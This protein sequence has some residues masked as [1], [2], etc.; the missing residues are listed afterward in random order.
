MSLIC[1]NRILVWLV[2]YLSIPKSSV[3][4]PHYFH[5]LILVFLLFNPPEMQLGLCL[6][7]WVPKTWPAGHCFAQ[8]VDLGRAAEHREVGCTALFCGEWNQPPFLGLRRA[9][10]LFCLGINCEPSVV[11]ECG[12]LAW[13]SLCAVFSWVAVCWSLLVKRMGPESWELCGLLRC[14]NKAEKLYPT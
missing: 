1:K 8:A 13:L 14:K 10:Y 11:L 4:W 5:T 9:S 12:A 7:C 3:V 6:C 2:L